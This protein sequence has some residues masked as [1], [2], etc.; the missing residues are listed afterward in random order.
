MRA[1]VC[2]CVTSVYVCMYILCFYVCYFVLYTH[3]YACV[4]TG[5]FTHKITRKPTLGVFLMQ[6]SKHVVL[7]L[8]WPDF[9]MDI[10]HCAESVFIK[11]T[12]FSYTHKTA[13]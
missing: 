3:V 6:N 8:S 9:P 7:T 4:H 10:Y 13:Y 2:V 12:I 5:T 1:R 11:L